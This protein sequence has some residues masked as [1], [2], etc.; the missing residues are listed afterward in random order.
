M[1][2]T[3]VKDAL[4]NIGKQKVS[5]FAIVVIA[6][7]SV[8]AYLG[9][10]FASHG[11]AGNGNAFYDET[12][13]RDAEIV[14]TLLVTPEDISALRAVEGVSDVEGA[15]QTSGKIEN[16]ALRANVDVVSLTDRINT[17][18]L[19]EGRLPEAADECAVEQP[20]LEALALTVGDTICI[21]DAKGERAEYLLSDSFVITGVIHHPD[22]AAWPAQIPGKRYVVVLPEAFDREELD[23]CFMKA[24]LLFDG[25]QGMDRFGEEYK[26]AVSPVLDRLET[27]S[28][29]RRTIRSSEIRADYQLEIDS[30]RLELEDGWA[31][32]EDAR[33]ELTENREILEESEAQLAEAEH[34]LDDSEQRLEEAAAELASG[35]QNL[36]DGQAQIDT[37]QVRLASA[38]KE[39]DSGEAQLDDSARELNEARDELDEAK[40]SLDAAR[41]E[42]DRSKD[43]LETGYAELEAAKSQLRDAAHAALRSAVGPAADTLEWCDSGEVDVNDPAV[44][45]TDFPIANG[46]TV[47]LSLSM[48]ENI[49]MAC[50]SLPVSEEVLLAAYALHTGKTLDP[51]TTAA[52]LAM[53]AAEPYEEAYEELASAARAW[54]EGHAE[55]LA[56]LQAYDDGLAA[57]NEG[58]AEYNAGLERYDAARNELDTG[59]MQYESSL[60]EYNAGLAEL[61]EGRARYESGLREYEQGLAE[62]EEGRAQYEDG[63][64]ELESGRAALEDGETEYAD[65]LSEYEDGMAQLD[66]AQAQLDEMDECR[67]VILGMEG[68]PSYL[69]VQNSV[70]NTADMGMTFALV[71]VMVGALVIYAT[72]GRI[73]DEQRRLVGATKALGLFNREI[74]AK[75][76]GFGVS[77]TVLGMLLGTV[78]GYFGIQRI[79][80][81]VYGRYYVFGAGNNAFLGR[82]TAVVF[83]AGTVLSALA[84][85]SACTT[86]MRSTATSLMQE[87][88]P[89]IR[90]KER[91]GKGRKGSLYAR[92]ILLNM[93][94]DK[95]RVAVTVVSIA[96]CCALLVAGFTM[97]QSVMKALDAQFDEIAR[98]DMQIRFDPEV[99][100]KAEK[101]LEEILT[102]AGTDWVP[103]HMSTQSFSVDGKLMS[104]NLITG[105]LSSLD[106]FYVR[107][108]PQKDEALPPE[109]EGVWIRQRVWEINGVSAGDTITFYDSKMK[110]CEL[111]VAG[112]FRIYAGQE[113]I[114]AAD[115]YE[116]FFGYRPENN[117]FF[118][119]L[120]GADISPLKE[121]ILAV[122]GVEEITEVA[123]TRA[124]YQS[125]ASV[126]NLIAL[127]FVGIAGMMAYF[128]LLNLV[129]MYINQKKRELTIMRVNGFTVRE[130][131]NYVLREMVVSTAL[132]IVLGLGA[133]ALLGYRV[134]RLLESASVRFMRGVQW[135]AWLLAALIT[136]VFAVAINAAALRKVRYLKLTDVA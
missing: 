118:L 92:L 94:T 66:E 101:E 103:V 9:I 46:V 11:I 121:A 106:R 122:D 86:L 34:E 44:S 80:L 15:Y 89:E 116:A 62:L 27:M 5:W 79:L 119:R 93:R 96:G 61:N 70:K 131:D 40:A 95:K 128:I 26:A 74:F 123:E 24:E 100:A 105:D 52:D 134:I 78:G 98:Y 109:G 73:V 6:M 113:M 58:L 12:H 17:P 51:S 63:L 59:R 29:E 53:E 87:K 104:S 65:K 110:P 75:Y 4:R 97:R 115:Q 35:K 47:D 85:W 10:N 76:L 114:L 68:N 88:A 43:E 126:L 54:D 32:L 69:S 91:T 8:M 42:L 125:L 49:S 129:N 133:G 102:A 107:L 124:M 33:T 48:Q 50:D 112:V 64:E 130:V 13:F 37:S 30:G 99:S 108:D 2:R 90:H 7:L 117:A 56:G 14:S 20:V 1:K 22:H 16:G 71:F 3:Q 77:G 67:W 21:A 127:M 81:F 132:G 83:A 57:Y 72:V 82:M 25:T 28:A 135:E 41:E 45:A 111:P 84:V 120:N 60:A 18:L 39:L 36:D 23:G 31:A 38:K 19:L 55:Y 136:V